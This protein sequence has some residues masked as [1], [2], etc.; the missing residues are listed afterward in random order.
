MEAGTLPAKYSG[1]V[2]VRIA[3]RT[4]SE[5]FRPISDTSTTGIP[6]RR[7]RDRLHQRDRSSE[8]TTRER[9][10]TYAPKLENVGSRFLSLLQ[11]ASAKLFSG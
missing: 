8:P 11:S 4:P 7:G 3:E 9:I 6:R 1:K 2:S 10:E 5:V